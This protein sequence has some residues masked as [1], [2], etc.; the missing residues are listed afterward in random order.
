VR[1]EA[2]FVAIREDRVGCEEEKRERWVWLSGPAR[3]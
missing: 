2:S 3:L 1:L